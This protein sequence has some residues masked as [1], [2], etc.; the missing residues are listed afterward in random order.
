MA[1]CEFCHDPSPDHECPAKDPY[2]ASNQPTPRQLRIAELRQ[3]KLDRESE[4]W[5]N[6]DPSHGTGPALG[7]GMVEG[8]NTAAP[9][10][11]HFAAGPRE[12]PP[13]RSSTKP[14]RR[15]AT[16][17]SLSRTPTLKTSSTRT[18]TRVVP[19]FDAPSESSCPPSI[20]TSGMQLDAPPK[21]LPGSVEVRPT[22]AFARRNRFLPLAL[23]NASN[24]KPITPHHGSGD[25]SASQARMTSAKPTLT[26][27]TTSV[28]H[29]MEWSD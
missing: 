20:S 23:R 4:K 19:S 18:S 22:S 25:E 7:S 6:A 21:I 3:R 9:A 8:E 24:W 28:G 10:E 14:A 13:D 27:Q 5:R 2:L 11:P 15:N 29:L 17:C 26:R 1:L 12:C 16:T